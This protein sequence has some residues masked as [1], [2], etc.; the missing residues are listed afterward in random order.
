MPDTL[1]S[2][3]TAKFLSPMNIHDPEDSIREELVFALC[4]FFE[5]RIAIWTIERQAWPRLRV[6]EL[7]DA[8]RDPLD[9]M[10]ALYGV[11][12]K[13]WATSTGATL[14][15]PCCTRLVSR[16]SM[17]PTS[18]GE[19]GTAFATRCRSSVAIDRPMI[20]LVPKGSLAEASR[21]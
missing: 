5:S 12:L 3:R 13:S 9:Y 1:F 17:R 20:A 8:K 15:T 10:K 2:M 21:A 19:A 4:A 6:R 18:F 7:T 14:A 11:D 16:P